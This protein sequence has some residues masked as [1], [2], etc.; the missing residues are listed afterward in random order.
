ML[1]ICKRKVSYSDVSNEAA[2]DLEGFIHRTNDFTVIGLVGIID[3]PREGISD[4]I[5]KLRSAG[6]RVFMVTGDYF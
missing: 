4:V 1:I 5:T 2:G 3:P 6:I